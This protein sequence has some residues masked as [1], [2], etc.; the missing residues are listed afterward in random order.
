MEYPQALAGLPLA[1]PPGS[2]DI[3]Y[4]EAFRNVASASLIHDEYRIF[5]GALRQVLKCRD[6]FL[7][8]Y[9]LPATDARTWK[10]VAAHIPMEVLDE[11]DQ[12][13]QVE[14][15]LS[16]DRINAHP[17]AFL[18]GRP[19]WDGQGIVILLE[20]VYWFHCTRHPLWHNPSVIVEDVQ[21]S[22]QEVLPTLFA[23]Q[24]EEFE[25]RSSNAGQQ[26]TRGKSSVVVPPQQGQPVSPSDRV[27][28]SP[29]T[30]V[31]RA[32]E[33]LPPSSP[34]P[35]IPIEVPDTLRP[36]AQIAEEN[37]DRERPGDQAHDTA[38]TD[39]PALAPHF[40][41]AARD[42]Q[43]APETDQKETWDPEAEEQRK[44][45]ETRIGT[46]DDR[47]RQSGR[48]ATLEELEEWQGWQRADAQRDQHDRRRALDADQGLKKYQKE[49]LW[50]QSYGQYRQ[51]VQQKIQEIEAHQKRG[52]LWYRWFQ[53]AR[54]DQA[55]ADYKASI[56]NSQ[57][58]ETQAR[59][60]LEKDLQH[61]REKLEEQF[62]KENDELER[63][64]AQAFETRRIPEAEQPIHASR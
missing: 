19:A 12:G 23:Q 30:E 27:S 57:W 16:Q 48:L 21:Q 52:G 5:L 62:A 6:G 17:W 29:S 14:R 63:T 55:L 39:T 20:S 35:A 49:E 43:A 41:D 47:A 44:R 11:F 7:L 33:V 54:D 45:E 50:F 59:D 61:E 26:S 42:P 18:C 3:G 4:A 25:Q 32:Q 51:A 60:A 38:V 64:I 1:L 15:M 56:A 36:P 31:A 40:E 34:T 58:R 9:A 37:E 13:R 46:G 28:P 22:C 8:S 10:P 24:L 53:K 2:R